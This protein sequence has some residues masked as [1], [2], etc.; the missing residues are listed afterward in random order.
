MMENKKSFWKIVGGLVLG[1]LVL[2]ACSTTAPQKKSDGEILKLSA[3][4]VSSLGFSIKPDASFRWRRQILWAQGVNFPDDAQH[5][6]RQ[7]LQSLIEQRLIQKGYHFTEGSQNPDYEIIAAVILGDSEEG[8][9][10]ARL[11]RLYPEL[12]GSPESLEKGTLMLGIAK[13]NSKTL[14]WRGAIQI[15]INENTSLSEQQERLRRVVASLLNDL[16]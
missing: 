5:L 8:D 3:V 6:N 13:P 7:Q 1:S 16:P 4:T 12:G 9:T 11:A 2:V 10:L 15:F 14:L